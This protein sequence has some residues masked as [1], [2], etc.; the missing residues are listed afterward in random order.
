MIEGRYQKNTFHEEDC[1]IQLLRLYKN[2]IE[3]PAS[4]S[5]NRM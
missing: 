5:N 4:S 1:G 3:R 2:T